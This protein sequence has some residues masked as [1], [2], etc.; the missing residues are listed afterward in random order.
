[1]LAPMAVR[2]LS[3]KS[4]IKLMREH[5]WTKT[6]GGKHNVKM[7]KSGKRPIT[8]PKHGGADYS[9]GLTRALLRQAEIEL[10]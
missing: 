7:E 4:A 3:Q 10:E 5:G 9:K 6:V 1:M 8:L 2:P